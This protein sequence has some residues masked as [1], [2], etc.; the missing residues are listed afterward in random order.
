MRGLTEAVNSFNGHFV[1][2]VWFDHLRWIVVDPN[3]DAL[4]I[5]NGIPMSMGE[6]QAVG[7]DLKT[8]IEYGQGTEF[9]RTFPHIVEFMENLEKEFVF[10]TGASGSGATS[11]DTP[12]FHHQRT[13][14]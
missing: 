9:Q 12:S 4:F 6:I 5:E 11:W 10:S 7:K 1:A 3:T 8:H 2:E 14:R 13:D